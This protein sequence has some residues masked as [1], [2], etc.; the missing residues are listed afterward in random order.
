MGRTGWR[1]RRLPG[2]GGGCWLGVASEGADRIKSLSGICRSSAFS[3]ALFSHHI[4]THSAPQ[5][6]FSFFY[7]QVSFSSRPHSPSPPV[8]H[9]FFFFCCE[10]SLSL[11][12]T[13]FPL[14]PLHLFTGRELWHAIRASAVGIV[15]PYQESGSQTQTVAQRARKMAP[16]RSQWL[17]RIFNICLLPPTRMGPVPFGRLQIPREKIEIFSCFYPPSP[18][19]IIWRVVH[20]FPPVSLPISHLSV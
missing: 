3:F 17:R 6:F 16:H 1:R 10:S 8:F 20:I 14:L 5:P 12:C 15:L 4:W 7:L 18:P 9:A 2:W 11:L 13:F 19:L